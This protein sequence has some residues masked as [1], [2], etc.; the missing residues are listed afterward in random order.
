LHRSRGTQW[1]GK[2][3]DHEP[4]PH[5]HT[6]KDTVPSPARQQLVSRRHFRDNHLNPKV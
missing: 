1:E 2:G 4:S 3:T 6:R 5:S